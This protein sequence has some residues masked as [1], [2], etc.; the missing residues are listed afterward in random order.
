MWMYAHHVVKLHA[1]FF[2]YTHYFMRACFAHKSNQTL[3]FLYL[4]ST[5]NVTCF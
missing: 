5:Q 1:I 4:I 2:A 3:C